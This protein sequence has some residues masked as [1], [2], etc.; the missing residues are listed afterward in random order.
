MMA[1]GTRDRALQI[2]SLLGRLDPKNIAS[3][4]SDNTNKADD[5]DEDEYDP[6]ATMYVKR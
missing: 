5:E 3:D 1:T 4:E 2:V 6:W